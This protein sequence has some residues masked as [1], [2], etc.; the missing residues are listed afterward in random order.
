MMIRRKNWQKIIQDYSTSGMS[1][2][3]FCRTQGVPLSNFYKYR[4]LFADTNNQHAMIVP[5]S[6]INDK[7]G[8]RAL[9]RSKEAIEIVDVT[10]QFDNSSKDHPTLRLTSPTGI[11]LEVFL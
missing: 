5:K 6:R 2:A 8:H 9:T 3:E 10:G 1:G 4:K 11:I 7:A